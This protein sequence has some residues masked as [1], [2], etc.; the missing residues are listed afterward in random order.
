MRPGPLVDPASLPGWLAPLVRRTAGLTMNDFGWIPAASTG[1]GSM[2]GGLRGGG[3][4]GRPAAVLVLF[5]KDGARAGPDVLLQLRSQDVAA[6]A[7]QVSFPGGAMDDTDEGPVAAALREATEEVGV[8]A[9]DVRP[10]AVLPELPVPPSDFVVTPVLGHWERPGPVAPVDL[11]ETAA[12]A[13]VPLAMLADPAQRLRVRGPSGYAYPG[14][15]VPGMLVWGFT[16]G[17][18]DALL[19]MGGWARPWEP[20]PMYDLDSAWR[21]AERTEVIR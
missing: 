15:V 17:L 10:V 6:H 16:G 20:A 12:V 11:A 3:S 9:A 4:R 14:F 8:R 2:R 1:D 21:L 5:A 18:L 19:A 13:R 7:G